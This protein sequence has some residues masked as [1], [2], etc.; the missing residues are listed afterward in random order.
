MEKSLSL[1]GQE[2]IRTAVRGFADLCLA[3]RP[4]DHTTP[5]RGSGAQSYAA[6]RNR[7]EKIRGPFGR[8][9]RTM[10]STTDLTQI[11]LAGKIG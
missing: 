10:Y 2:R 7:V 9:T 1:G 3:T 5:K 8:F 6:V 4:P 11:T